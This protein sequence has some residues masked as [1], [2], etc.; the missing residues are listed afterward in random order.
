M[1]AAGRAMMELEQDRAGALRYRGH[2]DQ[3]LTYEQ[4]RRRPDDFGPH[5]GFASVGDFY[6]Q[7]ADGFWLWHKRRKTG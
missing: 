7:N 6:E 1:A 4:R 5:Y 2:I 3:V